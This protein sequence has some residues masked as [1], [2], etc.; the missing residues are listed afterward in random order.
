MICVW[1]QDKFPDICGVAKFGFY[2]I[3][4]AD[5]FLLNLVLNVIVSYVHV[6]GAREYKHRTSPR[7]DTVLENLRP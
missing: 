3:I 1:F 4:C 5:I 7:S 6:K 2:G